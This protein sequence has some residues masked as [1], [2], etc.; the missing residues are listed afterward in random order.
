MN[1]GKMRKIGSRIL[2]LGAGLMLQAGS[3][4]GPLDD[5]QDAAEGGDLATAISL[6]RT[7]ARAGNPEASYNLALLLKRAP[8]APG[9]ESASS[10][11]QKAARA[12]LMDAYN[13]LQVAAIV[14]APGHH[15]EVA[16][17]PTEW[18]RQ[19]NARHYTLQL[20]SSTL[21]SKIERYY[22]QY[23][24][25]G[26][27][28]YFHYRR[29]GRDWYALVYGAYPTVSAARLAIDNLPEALRTWKPWVR[30]IRDIQKEMLPPGDS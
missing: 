30:R 27:G 25:A 28:G 2:L 6:L 21:R 3:L 24:I 11:L 5:A 10:W 14:A 15:I 8:P 4:A 23:R 29:N 13:R 7:L 16:L 22:G 19:Q 17:A 1:R 12:G 20:A 9:G 18:V 26:Q